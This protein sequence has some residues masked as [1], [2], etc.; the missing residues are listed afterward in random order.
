MAMNNEKGVGYEFL[1][2]LPIKGE[3]N[4][5]VA[6]VALGAYQSYAD[7][8]ARVVLDPFAGSGTT[9]LVASKLSRKS[10]G[11]E[12]SEE[13]CQLAIDRNKQSVMR[14]E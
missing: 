8:P 2:Y 7:K 6:R 11:Y 3:R 13:Y 9:L 5:D 1:Q 10:I 14:L 12:L 4:L